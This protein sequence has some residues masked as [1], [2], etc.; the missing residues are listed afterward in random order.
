MKEQNV[1]I[2]INRLDVDELKQL[3]EMAYYTLRDMDL[4]KT[5]NE[6]IYFLEH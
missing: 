5:I 3:R 4:V 2:D 1:T 6:R